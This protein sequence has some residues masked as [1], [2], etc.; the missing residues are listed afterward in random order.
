[1]DK[2]TTEEESKT[3]E[4]SLFL[5]PQCKVSTSICKLMSLAYETLQ[6]AV[7]STPDW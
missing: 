4:M 1:M 2:Y 7:K 5:F 3:L 6:E